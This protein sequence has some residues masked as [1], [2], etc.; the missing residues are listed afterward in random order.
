[1]QTMVGALLLLILCGL[2]FAPRV[3]WVWLLP[4]VVILAALPI[5][6]F[7]AVA[8]LLPKTQAGSQELFLYEDAVSITHVVKQADGQYVLLSDLQRMDAST[9]P[10]AVALQRNQARLPL[11]LHGSPQ[12]ILF[13]GLGTGITA[14]GSL[15]LMD[16]QRTAVELSRG[17]ITAAADYF[18]PINHHVLDQ[19]QVVNHDGRWFLRN[20]H[21]HYDVIVGD[22]FHPDMA[23]RSALLSVEQFERAHNCLSDGGWFVQWLALNQFDIEALQVVMRSFA[24]IFPDMLVFIDGFRLV[25]AGPKAADNMSVGHIA[26]RT[27]ELLASL[28]RAEGLDLTG[29]EGR[30]T[31]LGRYWGHPDSGPGVMQ[32]EWSPQIEFSLPIA[33]FRGDIDLVKVME[34]LLRQRP[35]AQSAANQLGVQEAEFQQFERAY[36]GST[37]AFGSWL[38]RL[39][40]HQAEA[41][42]LLRFAH[43]ANPLD[44][45]AGL[46]LADD[47]LATL[48]Q[49]I[50]KGIDRRQALEAILKVRPDHVDTLFELWQLAQS[51]GTAAEANDY[52]QR[53]QNLSPFD[54]RLVSSAP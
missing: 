40:G 3:R 50:G 4:L 31:W 41:N 34:W 2:Y 52:L 16:I 12:S 27:D 26:A 36:M 13:L 6:H 20:C 24:E 23:G 7:P 8:S 15:A 30:M 43:Q 29:G 47:M 37:L 48:P 28:G 33:R 35:T 32:H 17:A 11:L 1:M 18:A 19:M 42:R 21:Q 44:R 53:L 10:T 51:D 25:M 49:A 5:R 14:S 54:R 22:V 39:K 38:A 45:W 9:E 46:T